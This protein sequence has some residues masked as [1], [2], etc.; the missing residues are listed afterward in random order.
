M[1]DLDVLV[2]NGEGAPPPGI[3]RTTFLLAPYMGGPFGME[4]LA[5]LPKLEVIQLLSAGVGPW[6]DRVP[7]GVVLSNGRGVHGGST[8]ELAVAGVLSLLRGLPGFA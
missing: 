8:A 7:P 6:L 2:W 1:P 3:E 4:A 5:Q